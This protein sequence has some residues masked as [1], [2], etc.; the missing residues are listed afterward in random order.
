MDMADQ[1][2]ASLGESI[3]FLNHGE[4]LD[5]RGRWLAQSFL[6]NGVG[7]ALDIAVG[8][9]P[10]VNLLDLLVMVSLQTWSFK[11]HWVP[12]GI[13]DAGI[14][15][16]DRLKHAE[17]EL[18][19]AAKKVLSKDQMHTLRKLINAWISQNSDRT[20]VSLVRFAE[21]VDER[22]MSSL[23]LRGKAQGLLKEL[24]EASA[25]VDDV[26]L[27]GERLLWFAGR[28]PDLLGEQTELTAYR[29][30]DQPEGLQ[31]MEAIKSLQKLG[32]TLT[33]RIGALESDLEK[34]QAAFFARVSA[35]RTAAIAQ[36]Q[37]A[38]ETTVEQSIDR[39]AKS[40]NAERVELIN[41]L[42]DRFAAER[43]LLLDDI[44]A[45]KNELLGIM[46]E[47]HATIS[48][49]GTLAKEV[50]L[51]VNAVDQ[52]LSRFDIDSQ[53][54]G[55]P[56]RLADARDAARKTGRAAEQM[57]RLLDRF[58]ELVE[59]KS[60]DHRLLS[61]IDPVETVIDRLFWRGVILICLLMGG[62]ALLRL[63]PRRKTVGGSTKTNR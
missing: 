2:T 25:A 30:L 27:M 4:K 21:F 12:A 17:A 26:R 45:R 48:A 10:A 51:T 33:K 42:F 32:A 23:S 29:L 38:L 8:P 39:A 6:R 9:N 7:A 31:L 46:S 44:G 18:W 11:T 55:E 52:M 53:D 40:I 54:K 13:G 35:E 47:L 41:Q 43:T 16:V 37:A 59:S 49:S 1:Y 62:L 15:T 60:L 34:Q 50:T 20:V 5:S 58:D 56:F 36:A 24:S 14:P 63:A 22:R 57:T 3:Y 61:M 28:Y 19:A